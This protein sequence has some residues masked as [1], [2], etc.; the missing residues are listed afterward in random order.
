MIEKIFEDVYTHYTGI[1]KLEALSE[2]LAKIPGSSTKKYVKC[3]V[4]SAKGFAIYNVVDILMS[5]SLTSEDA[6][7][8]DK[9]TV[10]FICSAEAGKKTYTMKAFAKRC[11]QILELL[12][13]KDISDVEMQISVEGSNKGYSFR[14]Y[15]DNSKPFAILVRNLSV[16]GVEK[17]LESCEEDLLEYISVPDVSKAPKTPKTP[18]A[19]RDKKEKKPDPHEGYEK[20]YSS[21]EFGHRVTLWKRAD[22]D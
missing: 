1:Q 3:I 20:V 11:K 9:K 19:P 6:S 14:F 16:K 2:Y 13:G 21:D 10:R 15:Y 22:P 7:T 18:R 12:E 17:F 4:G 8:D 5:K